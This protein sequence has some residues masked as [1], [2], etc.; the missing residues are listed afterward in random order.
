MWCFPASDAKI[1]VCFTYH[2]KESE[3]TLEA[4]E[5]IIYLQLFFCLIYFIQIILSYLIPS[6][7]SL[8][9]QEI[10]QKIYTRAP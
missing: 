5:K 3:Y 9:F 6:N 8:F 2:N 1:Y 4:I 10:S 7:K